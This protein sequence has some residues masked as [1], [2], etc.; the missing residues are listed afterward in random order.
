MA[1][2]PAPGSWWR[3]YRTLLKQRGTAIFDNPQVYIFEIGKY[4]ENTM[5]FPP[6]VT[7]KD[8]SRTATAGT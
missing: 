7:I 6:S 4:D 3:Y 1:R 8:Y 5:S 2:R